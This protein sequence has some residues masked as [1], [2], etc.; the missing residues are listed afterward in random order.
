ME[1]L[2]V[3]ILVLDGTVQDDMVQVHKDLDDM[4][5]GYK[6]ALRDMVLAR[7]SQCG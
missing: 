5:L 6:M 1:V 2:W 4:V 7:R 3:C